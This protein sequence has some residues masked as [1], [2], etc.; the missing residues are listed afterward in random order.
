MKLLILHGT[1]GPPDG[2]W[3]PWLKAKVENH[4]IFAFAPRF[5]T[6]NGQ[7]K[8]NWDRV[9]NGFDF[10]GDTICIG[11]SCGATYLL[12]ILERLEKPIRRAI[13]VSGFADNLGIDEY[14]KLNET[15]VSH[16]FDFEKICRNAGHLNAEGG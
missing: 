12:H 15:F 11:H 5:P 6:P 16:N 8:E 2:N 3:F 10:D 7:S 9:L 13:F 14:D 1:K 4:G